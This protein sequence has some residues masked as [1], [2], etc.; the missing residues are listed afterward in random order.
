MVGAE[1]QA[2]GTADRPADGPPQVEGPGPEVL[3]AR[4]L[5]ASDEVV[6]KTGRSVASERCQAIPVPVVLH[7]TPSP[8]GRVPRRSVGR[9]H[10]L[11]VAAD[12]V[13]PMFAA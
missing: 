10:E 13:L 1:R 2:K 4:E 12:E 3:T 7:T 9:D 8:L 6:P 11:A 5:A